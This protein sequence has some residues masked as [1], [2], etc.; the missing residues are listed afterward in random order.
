MKINISCVITTH[1]RDE[2]LKEA[3]YSV[4]NQTFL[5]LEI[6]V[7][8]NVPNKKTQTVVKSMSEKST[9]PIHYIEHSMNGK[10]SISANLAVSKSKGDYIAFLMDDDLWEKSYLE[11]MSILI[12]EKKSKIIY[13][14]I[15]KIQNNKK[16]HHKKLKENLPMKNFILT[17]PGCGVSN[18]VV[19]RKLFIGLGG[20]DDYINPSYDKDFLLRALYYDYTYDVLKENL[21]VQRKHAHE[22]LSDIN[23]DTLIGMKK[24]FKKHEWVVGP[25]MKIRFWIK[26]LKNLIKM[27]EFN[28]IKS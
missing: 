7:S 11:K 23:E 13:S 3:I 17:N 27:L 6:I 4:I 5:P 9:V 14:W 19:D 16:T 20:F 28:K 21:V 1:N 2:Y 10:A 26:Y 12:S 15:S 22:Q 18:L 8:N 24:F 25:S